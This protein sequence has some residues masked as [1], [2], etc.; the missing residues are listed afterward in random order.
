MYLDFHY[1]T[2]F[3]LCLFLRF[4]VSL[5]LPLFIFAFACFFSF[6]VCIIVVLIC[7]VFVDVLFLDRFFLVSILFPFCLPFLFDSL[8]SNL[9]L[10][11][12]LAD[13]QE[14]VS[15]FLFLCGRNFNFADG[16]LGQA[17][18]SQEQNGNCHMAPLVFKVFL[19]NPCGKHVLRWCT[20]VLWPARLHCR[21]VGTKNKESPRK[22]SLTVSSNA[23]RRSSRNRRMLIIPPRLLAVRKVLG[24]M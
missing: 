22:A 2:I 10:L 20:Q 6:L 21:S 8:I 3:V 15:P 4:C 11:G 7:F 24:A 12:L 14:Y 5:L 9:P 23:M 18:W 1:R 16:S 19:L 17:K 13:L